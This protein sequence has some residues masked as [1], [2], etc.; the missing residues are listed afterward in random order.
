MIAPTAI[1]KGTGITFGIPS[2]D[3]EGA[4]GSYDSNFDN[5]A[6]KAAEKIT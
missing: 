2:I 5:K 3:V 1:I 6:R 4:T